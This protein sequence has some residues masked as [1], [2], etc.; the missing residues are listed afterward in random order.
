VAPEAEETR[1][2]AG[3]AH[4]RAAQRQTT[5]P[6]T[7]TICA[8]PDTPPPQDPVATPAG[9]LYS[10]EAILKCLLDQNREAKRKL[11]AWEAA[12]EAE[13]ARGAAASATARAADLLA[14][15]R[16]ATAG[17]SDALTAS[18]REAVVADAAAAEGPQ[19]LASVSAIASNRERAAGLKANWG[20]TAANAPEAR[21]G[22][23]PRPD[24]GTRCPASGAPLRLKDLIPVRFTREVEDD[25]EGGG[26]GKPGGSGQREPTT[27]AAA[28]AAFAID[29]VTRDPL[30]NA[31]ALVLLRPTG[32]VM[33]KATY[34]ACVKPEGRYGGAKVRHPHDVIP[35]QRGG[36]GF[37]AHDG[38][39][40]E[41]KKVFA[42][43]PGTGR[44]DVRGQAG[45]GGSKFGLRFHN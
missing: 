40:A 34:E 12:G 8:S 1:Q 4:R 27:T 6:L 36:T 13:A 20:V 35:L 3:P 29:P 18:I 45:V 7:S 23:G 26:A 5:H 24:T 43:G 19:R 37:A 41:A 44:A 30:T 25:D 2:K 11:A 32:D 39:A 31:S 38:G 21:V 33:L 9:Y 16:A 10:K 42:L 28:A 17:A 22:R 14:F 15:E